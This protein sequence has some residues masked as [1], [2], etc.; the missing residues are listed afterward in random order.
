G[1]V[2]GAGHAEA[3]GTGL[4]GDAAT[5]DA[6]DDVVAVV[7]LEHL[8]GLVDFLLVHLVGEVLL[9]GATVDLPLA[10]ARHDADA[11]DRVLAAPGAG[12]RLRVPETGGERLGGVL[13]LDRLHALGGVLLDI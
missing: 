9:K 5:R 12:G 3:Q 7:Q 1:L 2:Q 6:G 8:E 4:T 11:G 13:R 10:A